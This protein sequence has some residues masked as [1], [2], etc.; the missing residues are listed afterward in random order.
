M[1][2]F[3]MKEKKIILN[4]IL[5]LIILMLSI[6]GFSIGKYIFN[7]KDIFSY[8]KATSSEVEKSSISYVNWEN[9]AEKIL[10]KKTDKLTF[11]D[12]VS[13][14]NKSSKKKKILISKKK[15]IAKKIKRKKIKIPVVSKE[16]IVDDFDRKTY[17]NSLGENSGIFSGG[18]GVCERV[19]SSDEFFPMGY[20]L[21]L[22]YDVSIERSY[23]GFWTGLGGINLISYDYLSFWIKGLKGRESFRLE[24]SDGINN[25]G[26]SIR[27]FLSD[28][29]DS[30]WQK[31]F[32]PLDSSFK[33]INWGKMK[34]NL[35]FTFEYSEGL[36]YKST[37]FIERISFVAEKKN[38]KTSNNFNDYLSSPFYLSEAER[39]KCV[40]EKFQMS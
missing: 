22:D 23:A 29:R 15:Q 35:T 26:F 12:F 11:V 7:F 4:F 36:P 8:H 3:S 19:F 13:K 32:I 17:L 10:N 39:I 38:K 2:V 1:G 9:K 37:V 18:G 30:S 28:K 16:L 20:L 14:K 33:G 5:G 31:V 34:G 21:R 27:A 25:V 6:S 40:I 24:I